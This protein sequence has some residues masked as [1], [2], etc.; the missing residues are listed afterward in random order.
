VTDNPAFSDPPLETIDD[1]L[2]YG[3][4]TDWDWDTMMY[5]GAY[6][7]GDNAPTLVGLNQPM[8]D[9]GESDVLPS[10]SDDM[11]GFPQE[12]SL[13]NATKSIV[14]AQRDQLYPNHPQLTLLEDGPEDSTPLTQPVVSPLPDTNANPRLYEDGEFNHGLPTPPSDTSS[15]NTPN[16]CTD[17]GG[18]QNDEP[19]SLTQSNDP[20]PKKRKRTRREGPIKDL[21]EV[22]APNVRN[23]IERGE[24]LV[25]H[26]LA[27]YLEQNSSRWQQKGFW[28]EESHILLVSDYLTE[29]GA[30]NIFRYVHTLY[31]GKFTRNLSLRVSQ[32]LLYLS[33]Q[34]LTKKKQLEKQQD[35]DDNS[36]N[37]GK[38]ASTLSIDSFLQKAY[39][40]WNAMD[41]K[42]RNNLRQNFHDYTRHGH[43]C[44]LVA[45]ILGLGALLACGDT[46]A[47]VM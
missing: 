45:G 19:I 28:F 26:D 24:G 30:I 23:A 11:S 36:E 38:K 14:E 25:M 32:A 37:K 2:L 8:S 39:P 21:S 46:L 34:S 3:P 5:D 41:K 4:T 29:E 6:P 9:V 15:P 47:Q 31:E 35:Q 44:W 20:N 22:C 1:P 12:P 27:T 13:Y 33:W 40:E 42:V 7:S 18:D 10:S 43:R 16:I 17:R